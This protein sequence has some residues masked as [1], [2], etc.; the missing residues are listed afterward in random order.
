MRPGRLLTVSTSD[1]SHSMVIPFR[2]LFY[3]SVDG[4]CPPETF[5]DRLSS[6]TGLL[7]VESQICSEALRSHS[8]L[9]KPII[10]RRLVAHDDGSITPSTTGRVRPATH[11]RS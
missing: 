4:C 9:G 3:A 10:L 11:H 5:L 1:E 7:T 2:C 8:L 6:G